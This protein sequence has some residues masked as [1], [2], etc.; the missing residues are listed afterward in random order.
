[1]KKLISSAYERTQKVL[2][3]NKQLLE[4]LISELLERET[5]TYDEVVNLI[6]PPPYKDKKQVYSQLYCSNSMFSSFGLFFN[7][8]Q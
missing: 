4:T 8:M 6:G 3:D 2:D 5:L 1:M 7:L